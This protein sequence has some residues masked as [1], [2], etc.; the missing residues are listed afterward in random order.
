MI[1]DPQGAGFMLFRGAG[2]PAPDL[3]Y[4]TPGTAGWHELVATDW[5]AVFP[6]Y[7]RL[8]GWKKLEAM[9]MG[10]AGTY[11]LLGIGGREAGAMMSAQQGQ[12]TGWTYYFAVDDIDTAKTRLEGA[13][14]SVRMGPIEVPG[15][16]WIVLATDPQ[17]GPFA[18]VGSRKS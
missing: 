2:E 5:P 8:F 4:M 10:P 16:M 18:L 1:G 6:F 17:G 3:A 7:E 11:Q 14:G 15:P 12:P 9:D 13:G